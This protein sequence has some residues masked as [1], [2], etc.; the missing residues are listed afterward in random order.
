MVLKNAD[1]DLLIKMENI[2]GINEKYLF[3]KNNDKKC[4]IN[5]YDGTQTKVTRED[6]SDFIAL[7]ERALRDKKT[8]SDRSNKYNK[9]NKEYHRLMGNMCDAKKRGNM[10][11]YDYWKQQLEEY[12]NSKECD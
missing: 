12:K 1:I 5:W 10:E 7:I 9:R 6:F 11:K 8:A 3:G 4:T 2:I